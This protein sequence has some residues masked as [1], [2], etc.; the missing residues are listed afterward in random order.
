MLNMNVYGYGNMIGGSYGYPRREIKSGMV[1]QPRKWAKA[2]I[3]IRG[4][5]AGN[6]WIKH[7]R[8]TKAYDA[9]KN[10]LQE[11]R[12]T[13]VPKDSERRRINLTRELANLE[14]E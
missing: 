13:Y 8:D 9:I 5:A 1:A 3:F 6:P 14:K 10:I 11:A 4:I 12:K 7:L 2:A